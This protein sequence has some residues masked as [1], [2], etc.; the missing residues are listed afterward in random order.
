MGGDPPRPRRLREAVLDPAGPAGAAVDDQA[1]LHALE[2]L[3]WYVVDNLPPS[4]LPEVCEQATN[5]GLTR[6][7]V[8]LDVRTKPFFE[9]LSSMFA[10]LASARLAAQGELAVNYFSLRAADAGIALL[11]TSVEG[12]ERSRQI[13]QNRYAAGLVA[14]SDVLQAQTQLANH[15]KLHERASL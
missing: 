12:Y 9:Q 11:R 7:A 6:L 3:G 2:D 15:G 13:A 8:V 1:S 14:K 4:V 5:T 10:D